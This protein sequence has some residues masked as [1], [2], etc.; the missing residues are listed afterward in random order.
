MYKNTKYCYGFTL[1]ELLIAITLFG[2]ISALLLVAINPFEQVKKGSDTVR[3]TVASDVYRAINN[4]SIKS[5]NYPW[6]SDITGVILSSTEGEQAIASLIAVGE[7][8]RSF[9]KVAKKDLAKVALTASAD[10]STLRICFIPESKAM[11]ND[12]NTKYDQYGNVVESCPASGCYSCLTNGAETAMGNAT[13]EVS[14]GLAGNNVAPA[15]PT[16]TPVVVVPTAVPTVMPTPTIAVT[17]TPAPTPT[18]TPIP[19]AGPITKKVYLVV[20][21]PQLSAAFGTNQNHIRYYGA[22]DPYTL[23]NEAIAWFK[24]ISNGR[25]NYVLSRQTVL[26]KYPVLTDGFSYTDSTYH[27]MITGVT[28]VHQPVWAN[29]NT[30]VTETQACEL[31][32]AGEID[33]MWMF[34]GS[35]FGFY[36]SRLAGTG[37]FWYNSPALTGTTCTRPMP[38]MGYNFERGLPEMIH[39]YGHRAEYTMLKV[40]T[41]WAR[42]RI[43]TNF[44]RFALVQAKATSYAY[45]GCGTTHFPPNAPVDYDYSN[46]AQKLTMCD[47]F[48]NYPELAKVADIVADI[49]DCRTWSCTDIGFYGYWFSH[50]PQFAGIGTDGK[51]NDWWDYMLN[52]SKA[53]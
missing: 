2:A 4:I 38:I 50:F 24:A 25:I 36:E 7:L 40:Y 47:D 13:N 14:G 49:A 17:P 33:E 34:G 43:Y 1:I 26:N 5:G 21:N 12:P 10:G 20:F 48:I 41:S 51:L 8:S 30:I 39:D 35:W 27:S 18:A 45:S 44:D 32:N 19:V 22:N 11:K 16:V 46:M 3:R 37:A 31:F 53:L 6:K 15:P 23:T 9:D 28:P 29:Y 52:P 42:T